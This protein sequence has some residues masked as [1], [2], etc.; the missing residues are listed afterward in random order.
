MIKSCS[1]LNDYLE[2]EFD[3]KNE[4]T[5]PKNLESIFGYIKLMRKKERSIFNDQ[6]IIVSIFFKIQQ[7]INKF[8]KFF[9]KNII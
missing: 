6:S 7:Q 5:N 3:L 1:H 9:V 8:L 2:R 4:K